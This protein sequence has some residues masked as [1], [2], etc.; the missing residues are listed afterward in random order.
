MD[1]WIPPLRD[2]F[3]VVGPV[4]RTTRA[5]TCA[6]CFSKVRHFRGFGISCQTRV[7]ED[8]L[9]RY[10][11][12]RPNNRVEK[13]R[14]INRCQPLSAAFTKGVRSMHEERH[15]GAQ[16]ERQR[17]ELRTIEAGAP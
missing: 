3:K 10:M 8:F 6:D 13:A 2:R 14:K 17:R 5:A 7:L 11:H 4:V 15:V 12:L 9:S 16:F 1:L